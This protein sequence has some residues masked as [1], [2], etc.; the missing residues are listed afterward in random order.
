MYLLAGEL[1]GEVLGVNT[2]FWNRLG[3]RYD[4]A[5]DNY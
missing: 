4:F 3:R 2:L 1:C 5:G